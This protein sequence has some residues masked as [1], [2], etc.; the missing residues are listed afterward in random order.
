M[1][2][3]KN[4]ARKGLMKPVVVLYWCAIFQADASTSS[5]SEELQYMEDSTRLESCLA[6]LRA[7]VGEGV[8]REELVQVALAADYDTNRALNFFFSS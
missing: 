6:S 3:L 2:P 1:F 5:S 7:I 4:L 8:P